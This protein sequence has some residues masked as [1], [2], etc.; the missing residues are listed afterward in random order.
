MA[1]RPLKKGGGIP[2]S[3]DSLVLAGEKGAMR[4]S[5]GAWRLEAIKERSCSARL[6]SSSQEADMSTWK[7]HS[8]IRHQPDHVLSIGRYMPCHRNVI[9]EI[10]Q[11]R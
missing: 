4:G 7:T 9:R 10:D 5:R 1:G 2:V 3:G 8:R 6:E 11:S